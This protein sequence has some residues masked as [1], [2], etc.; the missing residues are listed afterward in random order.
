MATQS[1]PIVTVVIVPRESFNIFA[2]IVE[3]I[4]D[5]T[6]PIFK[7]LVM[8][9]NAPPERRRELEAI[10]AKRP[11]CKIVYS[12]R[13]KYP[14]ELVNESI[15]LIDTKYAVYVDNDVEVLE[16]WLEHL[17]ACAEEEKVDCVH[18]IYLTTKLSDPDRKI[19]IA[20]GKLVRE[21]RGDRWY[22]DSIATYSGVRLEDYPDQRRKHSDFFEWH[23]VMF[24]KK[25]LEAVGPLD[26]LNIC[27]HLDY[28]FRVQKAGFRILLEPKSV[29]AY[30]YGRIWELRGAD[31]EYLLYRWGVDKAAQSHDLFRS[32]WNLVPESTARR[33]FWVQ[34]HCGKVRSTY[35]HS[36]L[37]NRM[38][39]LVG[40]GNMPFV[41][42]QKPQLK[43]DQLQKEAIEAAKG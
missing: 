23:T 38:R 43:A 11:T 32:K 12:N 19:H 5:V 8:E 3:R 33:Q 24:S 39:R 2:D 31:R 26:D 10:A 7:M 15:P 13:W 30:D 20:E 34:E 22:I 41:K 37:I 21:K 40:L 17:V 27:E 42:G 35:F 4:Y 16:G 25:L 9:G 28:T 1:E 6:S 36:K 29:V 14:H 18:P